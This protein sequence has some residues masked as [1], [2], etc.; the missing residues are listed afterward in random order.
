MGKWAP[1]LLCCLSQGLLVYFPFFCLDSKE[2][3]PKNIGTRK[4]CLRRAGLVALPKFLA[5][6]GLRA[7]KANKN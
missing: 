6:S 2:T 1:E 3:I 7:A 5:F 4:T